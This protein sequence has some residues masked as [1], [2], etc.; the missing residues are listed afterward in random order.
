MTTEP[1]ELTRARI[2]YEAYGRTTDFKNFRGEPMPKFD[3]LP[4]QIRRA[5]VNAAAAVT[6]DHAEPRSP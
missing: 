5:W 1:A 3:D 6:C 4:E 2:A